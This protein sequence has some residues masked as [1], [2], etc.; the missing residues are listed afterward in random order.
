MNP[1]DG[2]PLVDTV[3][4]RAGDLA[5][6]V[7]DARKVRLRCPRGHLIINLVVVK[8]SDGLVLTCPLNG[9]SE[10]DFAEGLSDTVAGARL[11]PPRGT[12][13]MIRQSDDRIGVYTRGELVI[14]C[15]RAKCSYSGSFEYYSFSADVGASAERA[16]N[17]HA[18]HWLT[19]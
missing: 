5:E 13:G 4:E 19:D 18:E 14:S 8:L 6:Q 12:P 3:R 17:R 11:R 2:R 16:S 7:A 1:A 10:S 15:P 9:L